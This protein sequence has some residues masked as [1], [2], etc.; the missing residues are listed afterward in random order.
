MFNK[1]SAWG[2]TR[3]AYFFT[4]NPSFRCGINCNNRS[5]AANIF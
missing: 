3:P 5:M 2:K 4:G 1:W